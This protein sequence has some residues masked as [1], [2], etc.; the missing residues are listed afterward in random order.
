MTNIELDREL[1]AGKKL[2][3]AV[4]GGADSMCLLHLL[5]AGG[6]DVCA[7]HFEHGI[8][9]AE[10]RR[11]A[12]FVEAFCRERGI[13]FVLEHADVPAWA[14]EHGL[15]LEEAGRA[16]RYD[17][18]ERTADALGCEC[19]VTAHTLDDLA[20]T[21][22][23]NLARGSGASGLRGIPRQRG[24]I[25]RPMLHVSREQVEACL[26]E[27]GVPHVEDSTNR[28]DDYA[29]NL[30]RHHAV[31][32]LKQINPRFA[33]A[34]ARAAGLTARDE[35]CLRAEAERFLTAHYR[36]GSLPL[37]EL[38]ELHPAVSSRVVRAL[39]PGLSSLHTDRVLA[40]LAGTEYALLELPGT[41]LRR[42]RGRLYFTAGQAEPLPARRI[43]PGVPLPLPEAG[44]SLLA[45][46]A[47]YAGEI[48]DLFKTSYLKCEMIGSGLFCTGRMP[49]DRLRPLG[50]GCTKTLRALFSEH[51]C[52]RAAR[53]TTP[54]IRCDSGPLLVY[55]LA[56][57]ERAAPV[58]GDPVWKLTFSELQSPCAGQR[59]A[60]HESI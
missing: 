18:L 8:R 57:D 44:L 2:L 60:A 55:G 6:F 4:S 1:I 41:V 38:S 29:R 11:D 9:G 27:Q 32:A 25:V 12:A 23:F 33:E 40:F 47:V 36:G 21:L 52:T 34:A 24:R 58:P 28:S 39:L 16:L 5:C 7:A 50:R 17:F 49:G 14:A 22:L 15:G 26:A 42:E 13:P 59:A 45:E 20:E 54:V 51:G 30:I 31:P 35:D 37:R 53:D 56:L 10:S 46:K 43:V 48:H 19:I 3:C